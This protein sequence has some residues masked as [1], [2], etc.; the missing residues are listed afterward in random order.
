MHAGI[1]RRRLVQVAG[2]AM[3]LSIGG[4]ALSGVDP[5]TAEYQ[6]LDAELRALDDYSAMKQTC[7]ARGGVLYVKG[8]SSRLRRRAP[9]LSTTQCTAPFSG[10]KF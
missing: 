10:L 3:M 2:T 7:R 5:E 1:L 6:R 9:D 8:S 4:C